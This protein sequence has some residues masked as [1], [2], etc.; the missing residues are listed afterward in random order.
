MYVNMH[1]QYLFWG[2]F[3]YEFMMYTSFTVCKRKGIYLISRLRGCQEPAEQPITDQFPR[4]PLLKVLLLYCLLK[5][6]SDQKSL[7]YCKFITNCIGS[8]YRAWLQGHLTLYCL[9]KH[10]KCHRNFSPRN[11]CSKQAIKG[12]WAQTLLCRISD[13]SGLWN[14]SGH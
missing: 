13:S 4:A 8:V 10:L 9:D 7:G 5:R 11:W 1:V 12:S 14:D 3:W 2:A 6:L